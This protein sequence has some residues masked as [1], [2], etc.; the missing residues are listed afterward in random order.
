MMESTQ[1]ITQINRSLNDIK[2]DTSISNTREQLNAIQSRLIDFNSSLIS[3]LNHLPSFEQG[4]LKI[5]FD[6]LFKSIELKQIQ[7]SQNRFSFIGDPIPPPSGVKNQ[8]NK[9]ISTITNTTISNNDNELL[10]KDIKDQYIDLDGKGSN[11]SHLLVVNSSVCT[12]KNQNNIPS[13]VHIKDATD[14]FISLKVDGPIMIHNLK[15][16]IL[17]LECKQ[18]RLHDL[19]NCIIIIEHVT[20]DQIVIENCHKIFV[21]ENK[22]SKIDTIKV[23]DFSWPN[24]L[25][26]NPNFEYI[27]TLT[28]TDILKKLKNLDPLKPNFMPSQDNIDI[29]INFKQDLDNIIQSAYN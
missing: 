10:L 14:M 27:D 24:K 28:R 13:S 1:D 12:I 23:N 3:T 8:H 16:S 15:N 7:L 5:K 26:K 29:P 17:I 4:Q 11:D 21:T 20:N 18:L 6:V 19:D 22:V 9:K 2:Y 25:Y